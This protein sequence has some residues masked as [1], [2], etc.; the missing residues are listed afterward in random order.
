MSAPSTA[1]APLTLLDRLYSVSWIRKQL[2]RRWYAL[3]TQ[4]L[5][6]AEVL[7]LN[8]A[9]HDETAERLRL[10]PSDEANR[11]CIQLYH[12]V[13]AQG[14]LADAEVLEV[15]CGHGGGAAYLTRTM[16]PARYVGLDLNPAGIQFCRKRHRLPGLE[17]VCGDAE[18]L[19]FADASFDCVINVEASHCYASFPQFL[20][21]AARVL[22][23][24]G[25]LLYA[26]FRFE[27]GIEMW[28]KQLAAAELKK[29]LETDISGCVLR[30]MAENSNRSRALVS[31]YLPKFLHK[32]GSDFAGIKGSRVYNALERG[33]LSYRS[34]CLVKP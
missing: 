21:E 28:E 24:G 10:D 30:G 7:F 20:A 11:A 12:H 14:R 3:I 33:E 15:S 32:L 6:G 22:R 19:P 13:A 4:R 34:F 9:F 18:K 5:R 8:Y 26:D 31:R 2:W 17:F 23:R 27:D 29:E 1:S 25:V 16:K